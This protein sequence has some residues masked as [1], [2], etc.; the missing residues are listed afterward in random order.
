[1]KKPAKKTA[2][3]KALGALPATANAKAVANRT[4]LNARR[5][6]GQNGVANGA[7]KKTAAKKTYK[8]KRG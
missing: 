5:A 7:V 3:K 2:A 8:A 4:R 6:A 1:M